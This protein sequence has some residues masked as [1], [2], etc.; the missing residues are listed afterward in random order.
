MSFAHRPRAVWR[1]LVKGIGVGQDRGNTGR[2]DGFLGIE[3]TISGK[4]KFWLTTRTTLFLEGSYRAVDVD[5]LS[6]G[7][8]E[9]GTLDG[10]ALNAGILFYW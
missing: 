1:S 6:P 5:A 8:A 4:S 10:A 2:L 7:D 3:G 9:G